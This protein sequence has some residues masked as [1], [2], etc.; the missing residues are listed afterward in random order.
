MSIFSIVVSASAFAGDRRL[1]GVEI[2]R[3]QIDRRD[4]V[5]I[6]LRDMLGKVSPREQSAMDLRHQRFHA[7]IQDL[8]EAGV[9]GNFRHL[10]AGLAQRAGGAAGREDSLPPRPRETPREAAAPFCRRPRLGRGERG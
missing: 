10:E 2:H 3:Q 7:A 5:A 9:V 1:K 6:H 4:A 8:R